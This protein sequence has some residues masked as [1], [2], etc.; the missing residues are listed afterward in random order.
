MKYRGAIFDLDGT[1][2]DSMPVWEN[3]GWTY[4][5]LLGIAPP[6]DIGRTLKTMSL[7]EGA[8]YFIKELHINKSEQEILNGILALIEKQYRE[9]I[10]LKPHVMPFLIRLTEAGVKCCVVTASDRSLAEAAL[11]RLGV[12]EYF[13]FILTCGDTGCGK[14]DPAIFQKAL[15]MLGTGA[16]ETIV[17][18][19]ALHAAAT[20]KAA[21][22]TVAAVYDASAAVDMQAMRDAA[23]FYLDSFG[24]WEKIL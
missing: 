2:V 7:A 17:F 16:D 23:D 9:S 11:S 18:E 6:Q 8:A 14:N 12:L 3:I 15:C 13:A 21:G 20:A 1:L 4:I 5:A 24:E 10:P 19:D 22:L